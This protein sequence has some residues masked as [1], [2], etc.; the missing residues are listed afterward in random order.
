MTL[1]Y[2]TLTHT[3]THFLSLSP[4]PSLSLSHMQTVRLQALSTA[5][6]LKE[7]IEQH[8]KETEKADTE[9][10]MKIQETESKLSHVTS[11]LHAAEEE[12]FLSSLSSLSLSL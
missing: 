12:V 10:K 2:L 7:A 9:S 11:Q 5:E 3:N 8:K 1:Q 6:H 4:S